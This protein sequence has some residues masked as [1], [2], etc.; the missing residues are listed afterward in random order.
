MAVWRSA[1]GFFERITSLN[2]MLNSSTVIGD[3]IREKVVGGRGRDWMHDIEMQ[4]QFK[5]FDRNP[6]TGDQQN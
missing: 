4:D 3:G 6:T 2:G 5:D 1:A